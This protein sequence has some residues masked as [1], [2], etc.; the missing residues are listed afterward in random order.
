MANKM[1]VI[2]TDTNLKKSNKTITCTF[3][4]DS[5]LLSYIAN[6]YFTNG[7]KKFSATQRKRCQKSLAFDIPFSLA[8][9]IF[10]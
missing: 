4:I 8:T 10:F 5:P 2:I 7:N 6:S 1:T 9:V 3:Y